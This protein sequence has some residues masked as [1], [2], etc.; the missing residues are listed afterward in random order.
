V[1]FAFRVFGGDKMGLD[2]GITVKA[3]ARLQSGFFPHTL[4]DIVNFEQVLQGRLLAGIGVDAGVL[5]HVGPLSVGVTATDF[6]A[7]Q[8]LTTLGAGF[9]LGEITFDPDKLYFTTPKLN[10]GGGFRVL[11]TSFLSLGIAADYRDVLSFIGEDLSAV[12]WDDV[13]LGKLN[14]GA[15]LSILSDLVSVRLGLS[16]FNFLSDGTDVDE[17]G[18]LR[19]TI[20]LGSKFAMVE[21]GLALNLSSLT[22]LIANPGID[23]LKLIE[24]LDAGIKLRF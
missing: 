16:N 2:M 11:N 17:L 14:V 24:S 18:S 4:L 3:V 1:G 9:E 10:I 6:T 22:Q 12:A 15:E 13:L 23:S 19:P 5:L 21:V 20:G 8:W 7:V